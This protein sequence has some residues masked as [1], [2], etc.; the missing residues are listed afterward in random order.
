MELL[1]LSRRL[2]SP[3]NVPQRRWVRRNVS[4]LQAN[5]KMA[6]KI[7]FLFFVFLWPC[8]TEFHFHFHFSLFVYLWHWKMDLIFVFATL[9]KMDLNHATK[10]RFDSSPCL[11][12]FANIRTINALKFRLFF[13]LKQNFTIWSSKFAEIHWFQQILLSFLLHSTVILLLP[14]GKP[15]ASCNLHSILACQKTFLEL[16]DCEF[17]SKIQCITIDTDCSTILISLGFSQF[18]LKI[19]NPNQY[20]IGMGKIPILT[21]ILI[22]QIFHDSHTIQEHLTEFT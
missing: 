20:T 21:S 22:F 5:E 12:N 2:S 9:W 14:R 18:F 8:K 19:L 13:C 4:R 10:F 16:H 6:F 3:R 11:R 7:S 1:S 17:I 15:L